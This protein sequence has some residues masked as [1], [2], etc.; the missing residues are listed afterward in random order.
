MTPAPKN[1]SRQCRE[2]TMTAKN[3]RA[4]VLLKLI[5]AADSQQPLARGVLNAILSP[6]RVLRNQA[7][8]RRNLDRQKEVSVGIRDGTRLS[9][10]QFVKKNKERRMLAQAYAPN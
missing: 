2:Q 7:A 3:R 6:S 5:A 10:P 1:Y 4:E 8:D 9:T